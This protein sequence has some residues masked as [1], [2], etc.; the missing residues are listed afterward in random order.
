MF[1][2]SKLTDYGIVAIF[3]MADKNLVSASDL[4]VSTNIPEPT[5]AKILKILSRAQIV[6]SKRGPA[7][8]YVLIK[9]LNILSVGEII[10][11]FEGRISMTACSDNSH[12]VCQLEGLC[13]LSGR[14]SGINAKLRDFLYGLKLNM[15]MHDHKD[16]SS[17]SDSKDRLKSVHIENNNNEVSA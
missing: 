10:E 6:K 12:D 13:E 17:F 7:G 5:M 11:A 14:W 16:V 3:A 4:S 1:R 15:I 2:L 9:D 8:G